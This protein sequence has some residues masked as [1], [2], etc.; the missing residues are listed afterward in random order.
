MTTMTTTLSLPDLAHGVR[1]HGPLTEAQIDRAAAR[2]PEV[3][4][5]LGELLRAGEVAVV[6]VPGG[7]VVCPTLAGWPCLASLSELTAARAWFDVADFD[8][9][10][11]DDPTA[12]V[13][14]MRGSAALS[15]AVGVTSVAVA[16]D[17][18]R[19]YV[20]GQPDRWR[21]LRAVV[22]DML[23]GGAAPR[24]TRSVGQSELAGVVV[25]MA[26]VGALGVSGHGAAARFYLPGT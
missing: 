18:S 26:A 10:W 11:G 5:Y 14:L 16:G 3:P 6:D 12:A 19:V 15:V 4:G 2:Y 17:G 25:G 21:S 13:G 23:D 22:T 9:A 24:W 20:S 7:S 1:V 8:R